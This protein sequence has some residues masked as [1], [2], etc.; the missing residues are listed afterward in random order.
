[1]LSEIFHRTGLKNKLRYIKQVSIYAINK[2]REKR[3]YGKIS[4][5]WTPTEESREHWK[6]YTNCPITLTSGGY[7]SD[8]WRPGDKVEAR[9]QLGLPLGVPIILSSSVIIPKKRLDDLI[10]AVALVQKKIGELHLAINGYGEESEKEKLKKLV[11]QMNLS[12]YVFFTDYL[13]E[14]DLVKFYQAADVFV[15][16]SAKEGGPSSCKKALAMNTP[17]VMT[18]VGSVGKLIQELSIGSSF[19]VGD[20]SCCAQ[21]IIEA[22]K[23]GRNTKTSEI[24]KKLYSWEARGTSMAKDIETLWIKQKNGSL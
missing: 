19:S 14:S 22:I 17:V 16:L 2:K 15:H 8:I 4:H 23:L 13:C 21:K 6:E 24:A 20:V 3:L 10:K 9:K 1:M 18:P 11:E 12:K 5:L 7:D